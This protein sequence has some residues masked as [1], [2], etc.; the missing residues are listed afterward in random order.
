MCSTAAFPFNWKHSA[1]KI[2]QVLLNN[3]V[4]GKALNKKQTNSKTQNLIKA[5]SSYDALSNFWEVGV[6]AQLNIYKSNVYIAP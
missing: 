5:Q 2:Q 4:I 1:P 3:G 6:G